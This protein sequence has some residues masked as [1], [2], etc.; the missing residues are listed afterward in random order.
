MRV[1]D[2]IGPKPESYSVVADT[3]NVDDDIRPELAAAGLTF[4]EGDFHR[5]SSPIPVTNSATPPRTIMAVNAN[6]PTP[7]S[8]VERV[9]DGRP[10]PRLKNPDPESPWDT[11]AIAVPRMRR[12]AETSDLERLVDEVLEE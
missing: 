12:A 1:D 8:K 3:Q 11:T 7:Q 2:D 9:A 4:S 5:G 10:Q 6:L